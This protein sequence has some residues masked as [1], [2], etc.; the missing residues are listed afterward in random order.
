MLKW[1]IQPILKPWLNRRRPGWL[2]QQAALE[3]RID[4][5]PFVFENSSGEINVALKSKIF[6]DEILNGRRNSI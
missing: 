3:L 6:D 1:L 5:R 4:K 2:A